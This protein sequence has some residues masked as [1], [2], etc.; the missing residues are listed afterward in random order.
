M[1]HVH[2]IPDCLDRFGPA[3]IAGLVFGFHRRCDD[4]VLQTSDILHFFLHAMLLQSL[5]DGLKA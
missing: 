2:D 1:E 3:V 5:A 4:L